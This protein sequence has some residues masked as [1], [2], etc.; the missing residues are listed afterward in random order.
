VP[1]SDR[2]TPQELQ[3]AVLVAEG[4]RNREIAG[5]LFLSVRTVEFHLTSVFRKIG[6]GS[7]SQLAARIVTGPSSRDPD[8]A[9][10]SP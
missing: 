3:I 10:R 1:V 5:M 6:V 9:P 4:R 7:R 8:A 2:L